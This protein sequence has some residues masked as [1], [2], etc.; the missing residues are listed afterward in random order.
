MLPL[1]QA[2]NL[3]DKGEIEQAVE[4]AKTH[5]NEDFE[6]TEALNI[7]GEAALNTGN[8]GLAAAIFEKW[9]RLSD[10]EKP[11]L[12]LGNCYSTKREF[13]KAE[14]FYRQALEI[15]SKSGPGLNNLAYMHLIKRE[16]LECI[17]YADKALAVDPNNR[18]AKW[19]R[20]L[21]HLQLGRWKEGWENYDASLG[22]QYRE[23]V[24]YTGEPRWEGK[25]GQSVV[26][27]PEQGLG[28]ELSF[29]SC[30]PDLIKV[31]KEV[32]IECDPRLEGLF[33]RS[34]GC[35]VYGSR[36]DKNST[37]PEKYKFDAHVSLGSLPRF[38]RNAVDEFPGTPYLTACPERR[39]GWRAI[40][41]SL[42]GK[43]IG[44][45]WNGGVFSTNSKERSVPPELFKSLAELGTL[46]SLEYRE[47]CPEWIK[48]FPW[49]RSNDYDHL[50]ALV[51]ELDCV[52]S[53]TTAVVHLAGG[54]GKQVHIMAPPRPRWMYGM[55]GDSVPWYR[56][57][58]IHRGPWTEQLEQI[59][60]SIGSD[61]GLHLT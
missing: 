17:E 4:I 58:K 38:F 37:W 19:N 6:N 16:P 2:K 60:G 28:D 31:S 61:L 52:V 12:N 25:H 8:L 55:E 34:F 9:G 1:A 47:G 41:D 23:E 3:L 54:L 10:S 5:L 53:V 49:I 14:S 48:E 43:K 32:V 29:A 57:A 51:A 7:I 35:E 46:V 26:V 21:A 59:R 40:L 24:S 15:N 18:Y 22:T 27:S 30:I 56:S 11:L 20:S 39:K 36:F 45:S 50:A 42:P 44:V 13:V 33:K